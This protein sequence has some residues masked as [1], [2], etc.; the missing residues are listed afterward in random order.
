M[1]LRG[2]APSE[3]K[4]GTKDP[5]LHREEQDQRVLDRCLEGESEAFSE[6][7]EAYKNSLYPMIY[8]WVGQKETA[9]EI[10]QDVFLKAFRQLKKFRRESKF[11]TWLFQIALNRCRDF[12]RS[13]RVKKEEPLN[14]EMPIL[15]TKPREDEN[16][17]AQEQFLCLRDALKSL[18]PIYRE[19]LSLRYLNEMTHEEIAQALGESLSN[20]KMRV[21]RGLIRLRKKFQKGRIL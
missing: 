9:E 19:A 20:V 21:T 3:Q 13:Q 1:T 6:I 11:S 14:P 15:D 7:I 18:P 10:L 16:V 8:R 5:L 12:Y 4:S 2:L 17:S